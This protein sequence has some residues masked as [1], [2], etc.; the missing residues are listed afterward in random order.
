MATQTIPTTPGDPFYSQ[1]TRL[2]GRDYVLHFA[3]NQ[4]EE[5][6]YL[7]IHDEEDAPIVQGLK[8]IANWPLLRYYHSDSR[9]PPGEIIVVDA[10]GDGSPPLLDELGPGKRCELTYTPAT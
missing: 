10:T 4:R 1:T 5:R 2:D 3:W 8:L 7:S 6:W 9:V